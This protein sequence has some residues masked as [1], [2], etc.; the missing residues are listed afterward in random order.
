MVRLHGLLLVV[1][2][3]SAVCGC[4]TS[5]TPTTGPESL[6]TADA[7]QAAAPA[8]AAA[9]V[10]A[11][12]SAMRDGKLEHAY[13]LLPASYH[14]DIDGLVHE[15][16]DQMDADVWDATFG[17]LGK[18]TSLLK[19]KKELLLSMLPK[20]PGAE[21]QTAALADKWDGLAGGLEQLVTSDLSELSK[22]RSTTTRSVLQKGVGPLMKELVALSA[23]V[24]PP[25][26]PS[27]ADLDKVR[28]E[29]VTS[30]DSAATVKITSPNQAEPE[31]VE[32]AKVEGKWIPKSFADEWAANIEKARENLKSVGGDALTASKPQILQVLKS[33]DGALDQM[34][35]A[36]TPEQIQAA[37]FSLVPA[38]MMMSGMQG[39]M[40]GASPSKSKPAP[41]VTITVAQELS[42][43]E[44][45][46]LGDVL[47]DLVDDTAPLSTTSAKLD[48]KTIITVKPVADVAAFVEKLTIAKDA[49]VDEDNRSINASK[50]AFE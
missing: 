46:K 20:Q 34:L 44:L 31:T 5:S 14:K 36:E 39:Q 30:T 7:D 47:K 26:A 23:V 11:A 49:E 12:A 6:S 42:D 15:F 24:S 16:A 19:T 4:G 28:A 43:D 17:V 2:S 40:S 37:T 21:T 35:T 45:T 32:F 3:L 48:G 10:T 27:L 8:D 13:D 25:G 1:F 33:V 18:A 9:A 41:Q 29:V 38:A 22:L 50:L